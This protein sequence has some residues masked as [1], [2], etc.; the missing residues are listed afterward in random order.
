[1][2]LPYPSLSGC[3][4]AQASQATGF[5]PEQGGRYGAAVSLRADSSLYGLSPIHA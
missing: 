2:A 5:S 3:A 1:M 4:S